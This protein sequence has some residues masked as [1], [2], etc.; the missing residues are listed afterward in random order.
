L[1]HK[2]RVELHYSFAVDNVSKKKSK[3]SLIL[4]EENWKQIW[5]NFYERHSRSFWFYIFKLC[6]DEH[7]A[8]DIFQES[9]VKFLRAKPVFLNDRHMRA[10]LNKIAFRLII[11]QK[12]RIKVEKKA[13]EEEKQEYEKSLHKKGQEPEIH[14][15]MD[16]EKTF[17][18][19]KPRKRML[20]WLAYVEGYSYTE[21]AELTQTKENSVKV[22]LFRA[23]EELANI[24]KKRELKRRREP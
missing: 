13:F 7:M 10:Y 12:R 1:R 3:Q 22:Q 15:F 17:K 9:F 23:R 19:L 14:S 4:M 16:M 8:D 6:G 18:S 21:I 11:D 2:K 5:E 24:L 20:L